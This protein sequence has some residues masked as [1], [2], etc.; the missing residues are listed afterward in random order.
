MKSDYMWQRL[1]TRTR[2]VLD[3]IHLLNPA[4]AALPRTQ[5]VARIISLP[6]TC[7]SMQ[8]FRAPSRRHSS[9][10]RGTRPFQGCIIRRGR[11]TEHSRAIP[12]TIDQRMLVNNVSIA[13][14]GI[15]TEFQKHSS[16]HHIA[17]QTA[18]PACPCRFPRAACRATNELEGISGR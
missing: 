6:L 16:A 8:R 7:G 12:A 5:L 3:L 10:G 15:D 18:S 17:I 9:V 11:C 13:A 14:T 4:R 2:G 1:L